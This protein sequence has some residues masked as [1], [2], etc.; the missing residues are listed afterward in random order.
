MYE[1]IP[2]FIIIDGVNTDI[3]VALEVAVVIAASRAETGRPT[4]PH[5]QTSAAFLAATLLALF[6]WG[7][8]FAN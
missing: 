5:H 8:Y 7:N 2:S 3:W 6:C 1:P 4:G